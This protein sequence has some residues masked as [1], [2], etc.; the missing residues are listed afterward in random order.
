MSRCDN[1]KH[2]P[3]N[4]VTDRTFGLRG[5]VSFAVLHFVKCLFSSLSGL[6][7]S[8]TPES[9]Q[10]PGN[11]LSVFHSHLRGAG[12]FRKWWS[13]L[14]LFSSYRTC[15]IF[16]LLH[17]QFTVIKV[18]LSFVHEN[19]NWWTWNVKHIVSWTIFLPHKCGVLKRKY[20]IGSSFKNTC[21]LDFVFA[22]N[23][24]K[25]VKRRN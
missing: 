9:T 7:Q 12:P 23:A 3:Q 21:C 22:W 17:A 14:G 4:V 19:Q 5:F 25:N 16:S 15:F 1:R 20:W 24:K 2:I 6:Q 13:Q 11:C 10:T 8:Q 18:V